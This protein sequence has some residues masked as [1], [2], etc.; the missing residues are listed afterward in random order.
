MIKCGWIYCKYN[1]ETGV[2]KCDKDIVLRMATSKD[3]IEEG[4]M[5]EETEWS[6]ANSCN[7]LICDNYETMD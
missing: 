7:V 5:Q 1:E 2:C 6:K 4:I 3:L